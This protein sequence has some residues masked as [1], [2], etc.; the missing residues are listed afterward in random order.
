M[1]KLFKKHYILIS[2]FLISLS[3]SATESGTESK[4]QLLP[5]TQENKVY[6]Y[7]M[8]ALAAAR[9]VYDTM[10]KESL[11]IHELEQKGIQVWNDRSWH[12]NRNYLSIAKEL[13]V[14]EVLLQNTQNEYR[15]RAYG[16]GIG[17]AGLIFGVGMALADHY[18][19]IPHASENTLKNLNEKTQSAPQK[20][21]LANS[22]AH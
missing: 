13:R 12:P 7:M 1:S 16:R 22:K 15:A 5:V 17:W 2:L 11:P 14:S 8:S 3:A 6:Y 9:G 21:A 10:I 20:E 19:Y 18:G 4:P